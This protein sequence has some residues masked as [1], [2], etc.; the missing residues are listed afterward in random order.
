M[1]AVDVKLNYLNKTHR[2]YLYRQLVW[3]VLLGGQTRDWSHGFIFSSR[4]TAFKTSIL[5]LIRCQQL[6]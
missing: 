1:K 4:L 3:W 5:L 6:D 2:S